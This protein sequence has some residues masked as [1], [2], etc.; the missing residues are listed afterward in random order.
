MG[1]GV[2]IP[3]VGVGFVDVGFDDDAELVVGSG[4]AT[5]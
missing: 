3:F 1:V 2:A 5:P 4:T